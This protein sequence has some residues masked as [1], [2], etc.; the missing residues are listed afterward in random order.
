MEAAVFLTAASFARAGKLPMAGTFPSGTNL[1]VSEDFVIMKS[2]NTG[3]RTVQSNRKCRKT[4]TYR[5]SGELQKT[6]NVRALVGEPAKRCV[7]MVAA[8]SM[9]LLE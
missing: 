8:Q 2:D 5:K 3:Y 1:R 4:D 7:L 6:S 9:V